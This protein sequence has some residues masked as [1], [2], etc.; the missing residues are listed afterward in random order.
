MGYAGQVE[1]SG[2]LVSPI[3]STLY[4]ACNTAAST[5]AKVVTLPDYDELIIGTTVHVKFVNGNTAAN[6]TLAVGAT[7]AKPIYAYGTSAPGTTAATSWAANSM[8]SF[9]Y[10][11]TAWRMNDAG[12]NNAIIGLIN[13]EASAR[14]TAI[15][16]L[17]KKVAAE[18]S[19]TATYKK[20]Q[21]VT[22]SGQFYAAN[23]DIDPAEEW[24]AAHWTLITVGAAV[25]DRELKSLKF[26]N[27]VVPTSA[28]EAD[29][30]HTDYPQKA[31]IPLTGVTADMVPFVAFDFS[32]AD[33]GDYSTFAETYA[34]GVYIW[35]TVVPGSDI[36][37]PTII[38]WRP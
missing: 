7:A 22:Q 3:A 24:T 36:T 11:G 8:V 30:T 29:A 25:E 10:D 38:C 4:G 2:G 34:G 26:T 20:E 12:A 28:F 35:A 19:N 6:P 32:E 14:D 33:G 27:V 18:Y 37:I 15:S 17:Q 23:Q 31:T 1:T 5:A 13:T 9:T 21:I 16:N